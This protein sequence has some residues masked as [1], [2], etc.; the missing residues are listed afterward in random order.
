[1]SA[2][3][4]L[5][6]GLARLCQSHG[7]PFP[8]P[9]KEEL[10]TTRP[11]SWEPSRL[12]LG[13]I[14]YVRCAANLFSSLRRTPQLGHRCSK[15]VVR[16][17]RLSAHSRRRN[18]ILVPV[19]AVSR[20]GRGVGVGRKAMEFCGSIVRALWHDVSPASWMLPIAATASAR[21]NVRT[22]DD[23]LRLEYFCGPSRGRSAGF[24]PS[25]ST[26]SYFAML[27]FRNLHAGREDDTTTYRPCDS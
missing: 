7:Q 18:W 15:A 4:D 10:P 6:A 24:L 17:P 22:L 9:V 19:C 27:S 23:V 2:L 8:N 11:E 3:L 5:L 1:M 25:C 20:G 26:V 21:C 14:P 13:G 12:S 16:P